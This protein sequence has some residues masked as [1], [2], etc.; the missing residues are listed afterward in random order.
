[1]AILLIAVLLT[2][3]YGFHFTE[4]LLFRL[5]TLVIYSEILMKLEFID[6]VVILTIPSCYIFQLKDLVVT[7]CR[8]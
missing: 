6:V 5:Q 1:M 2:H 7:R 8:P 4:G 3:I